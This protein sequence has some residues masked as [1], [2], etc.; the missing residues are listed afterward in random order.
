MGKKKWEG[1]SV[2]GRCHGSRYY[3]LHCSQLWFRVGITAG[4]E[5]QRD[6]RAWLLDKNLPFS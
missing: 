6:V 4:L 2:L 3:S 5:W 1:R